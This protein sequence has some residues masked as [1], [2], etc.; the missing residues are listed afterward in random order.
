MIIG[1]DVGGTKA[2][3]LLVEANSATIV[4][5]D[6]ASST[7]DGPALVDALASLVA[8]LRDRSPEPVEAVG[9]GIAGLTDRSGTL[10]WSPNLPG[11]VGHPVGPT[12][13]RTV[14]LPVT[15]GNDATAATLAEARFGAGRGCDDLAL[16]TLGTGIGGGFV[17]GGHLQ[18]GAHGFSGE[19]GHMVVDAWGPVHLSGLRGPWEHYASGTALGRLGSEAAI[20]GLFD[21]GMALAGSPDAVTGFHVVEAMTAGD[22]QAAAV[23]DRWCAEVALG[24]ANLI[25]LLDLARV[26][27]GGGL[28]EVGEP[29]RDGVATALADLLPGADARPPVEVVLAQLGPDAGAVGAA[30]LAVGSG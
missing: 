25:V 13:E 11:A 12:L 18:Q 1:I 30:L 22:S 24:V 8:A 15:V 29:L 2:S 21:R 19:P 23:F 9:L 26:V 28:A 27:L 5:R 6:R 3:A 20:A 4:D 10:T 17:L 16:V 14:G 7:G